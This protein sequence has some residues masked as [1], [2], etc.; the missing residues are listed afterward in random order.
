M[1]G[2]YQHHVIIVA[3]LSFKTRKRWNPTDAPKP[4]AN[5]GQVTAV[6][7]RS[8]TAKDRIYSFCQCNQASSGNIFS[9]LHS[10]YWGVSVKMV[11]REE[12]N[13]HLYEKSCLLKT[14][15]HA[16][17]RRIRCNAW[18]IQRIQ[19]AI[20]ETV[21]IRNWRRRRRRWLRHCATSREF[22]GSVPDGFIGIFHWLNP[23]GR[24]M[25]LG[26]IQPL[27]ETST[28]DISSAANP[29]GA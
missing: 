2:L 25:A 14:P 17:D 29:D 18:D 1:T 9:L 11:K 20:F 24:N 7:E 27:T 22:A 28:W 19:T 16:V 23:S 26:P 15:M 12:L 3:S 8:E 21:F 10:G 4:W 6:D 5:F 13:T